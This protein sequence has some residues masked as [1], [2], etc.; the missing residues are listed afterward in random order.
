MSVPTVAVVGPTASGKSSVAVAVALELGD[1]E[2]VSVD[3][4]QVY[5][6]MDIGTAKPTHAER[7]AVPHHLIDLVG[8]DVDFAVAEFQRAYRDVMAGIDGRG[9]TAILVGG[10]GRYHPAVIDDHDIPGEWPDVR[11][12]RVG[13]SERLGAAAMHARLATLD[14][15][16]AVKMEPTN[17]RRIVRAL[18]VVEGSG[19]PF[20]SFGPGLDAYP[21]TP[22]RQVGIRWDR[23]VL[24]QRIEQRV[25]RMVAAGLV[26]EVEAI[27]ADRGFSRSAG[28]ALGYKEIAAHLQGEIGLDEAIEHVVVRTRQFAVRQLRWFGRDPRVAWVDVESDP[29]SEATPAVLSACRAARSSAGS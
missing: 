22:I 1:V 12:R 18:E 29:V 15:D 8:P 10:P 27:L 3:S 4:M 13:G 9:T 26:G 24:A 14:P 7:A 25:H 5:R 17:V 11:A 23:A 16:A 20:S 6:G 28:Q 2:L 21:P 19:R